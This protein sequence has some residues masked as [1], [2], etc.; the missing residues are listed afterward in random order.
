MN[1]MHWRE[2]RMTFEWMP[3]TKGLPDKTKE[4]TEAYYLVT[5]VADDGT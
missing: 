2:K 3:V 5:V 4:A 1:W